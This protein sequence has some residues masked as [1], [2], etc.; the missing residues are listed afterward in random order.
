MK[1]LL[2]FIFFLFPLLSPGQ[3]WCPPGATW[4]YGFNGGMVT[5]YYEVVYTGDTLIGSTVCKKL[6]R[7]CYWQF[8]PSSNTFSFT[9]GT[10]YTYADSD[11][12]YIFRH[13]QFYTMYDF[14][15]QPGDTW[16]V[17]GVK[18]YGS[19]CDSTG[20]VRVDST[21]TMTIGSQS[22]RYICVSRPDTSQHWGW[23]AKI[24][25][26]VGPIIPFGQTY[27]YLFPVKFDY[28]GMFIDEIHEGGFFRCYSDSTMFS[29]SSNIAPVCDYIT[30]IEPVIASHKT[31][32]VFPNPSNGT[33][34]VDFGNLQ[35]TT[36]RI[37][38]LLGNELERRS[39]RNET[40]A[41]LELP[42]G[43]YFLT[44]TCSDGNMRTQR[45]VSGQ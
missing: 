23:H 40:Q 42:A 29:Y 44:I 32:S 14:S 25:E 39:I 7:T 37:T 16:T 1:K 5:G 45:I 2:P 31:F 24:V 22:L 17:P 11:K 18:Y 21:G 3:N 27:D 4:H 34:T 20:L 15:A 30:A 43:V 28:C 19:G 10:A 6:Q 26:R 33:F 41:Q 8:L 36:L 13:N 9:E 38:D 35:A 12:V